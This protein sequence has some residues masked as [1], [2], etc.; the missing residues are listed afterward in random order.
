M[1]KLFLTFC[2]LLPICVANAQQPLTRDL[3]ANLQSTM[4]QLEKLQDK[5]PALSEED[6][7]AN[8][9]DTKNQLVRINMMPIG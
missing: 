4:I 3:V 5:F 8:L 9:F 1:K 2:L 6:M 7:N